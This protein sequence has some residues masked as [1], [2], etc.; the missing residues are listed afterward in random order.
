MSSPESSS[1]AVRDESNGDLVGGLLTDAK[2]LI[3]AHV[4]QLELEV[5]AEVAALATTIRKTGI[6]IA[7]FVLAGLL[8]GQAAAVGL[9]AATAMPLWACLAI[10][11]GAVA[12]GGALAARR[13]PRGRAPAPA[14]A[15]AAIAGD[16][17]RAVEAV[18][19]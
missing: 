1:S 3:D 17:S 13:R 14:A 4:D 10:V 6:A 9:S 16:A 5:R 12:M 2:E 7:A 8:L 19:G 18:A 11:G 15:I